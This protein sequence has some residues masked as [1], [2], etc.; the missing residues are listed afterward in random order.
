MQNNNAL[1]QIVGLSSK[2]T[3]KTPLH[4]QFEAAA[5]VVGADLPWC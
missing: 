2:M 5:L 1:D 4:P 3:K